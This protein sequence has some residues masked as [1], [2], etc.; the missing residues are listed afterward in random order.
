MILPFP[1]VSLPS[2]PPRLRDAFISRGSPQPSLLSCFASY[3]A[4]VIFRAL[5]TLQAMALP[6]LT[7]DQTAATSRFSGLILVASSSPI[8]QTS[9]AMPLP[10]LAASL[11]RIDGVWDPRTARAQFWDPRRTR[12][13]PVWDPRDPRGARAQREHNSG[14]RVGPAWDQRG[15][16]GTRVGPAHSESTILGPAWPLSDASM[17]LPG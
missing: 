8:S 17:W 4:A 2:S 14:T 9:A 6:R 3:S 15:T 1:F 11:L 5:A 12:V 16:R 7:P 10:A 13:G